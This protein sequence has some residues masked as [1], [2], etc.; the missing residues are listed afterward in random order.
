MA[1][2]DSTAALQNGNLEVVSNALFQANYGISD[3]RAMAIAI[4]SLLENPRGDDKGEGQ[5]CAINLLCQMERKGSELVDIV[6]SAMLTCYR[7]S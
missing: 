4:L 2:T 7:G 6:H 5:A 1:N 3:I